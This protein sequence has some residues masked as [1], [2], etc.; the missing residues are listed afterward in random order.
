MRLLNIYIE[1]VGIY[2]VSTACPTDADLESSEHDYSSRSLA[3]PG[4]P[5]LHEPWRRISHNLK[6][7]KCTI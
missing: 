5:F 4:K 3:R 2:N 1:S 7:T 6:E